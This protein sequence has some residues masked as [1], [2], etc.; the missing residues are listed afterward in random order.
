MK[1]ILNKKCTFETSKQKLKFNNL[2]ILINNCL[3]IKKEI[4]N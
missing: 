2:H 3:F 4:K 1:T